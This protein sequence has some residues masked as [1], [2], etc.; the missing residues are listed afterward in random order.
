MPGP[1]PLP[2][3]LLGLVSVGAAGGEPH[4][5][6]AGVRVAADPIELL[7]DLG[8]ST[9]ELVFLETR[10]GFRCSSMMWRPVSFEPGRLG[11]VCW[12]RCV[13]D[14][15]ADSSEPEC[16]LGGGL[17]T[18]YARDFVRILGPETLVF[19]ASGD[20]ELGASGA[21]LE[22]IDL[23]TLAPG[24]E[25]L[26]IT[27]KVP[28]TNHTHLQCILAAWNG[29]FRCLKAPGLEG[30]VEALVPAAARTELWGMQRE[31]AGFRMRYGLYFPG[32]PNC[33]PCA[34]IEATLELGPDALRVRSVERVPG[35][36]DPG[37]PEKLRALEV[38]PPRGRPDAAR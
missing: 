1:I 6:D 5:A 32:D 12:N 34:T 10:T 26:L 25:G 29:R 28:G 7:N 14:G 31:G 37:C 30:L 19:A 20:P 35:R 8:V 13:P 3:L 16:R 23:L 38:T 15:C 36:A 22:S 11:R 33:C 17:A 18:G 24:R 21:G 2:M 9:P 4:P 27:T